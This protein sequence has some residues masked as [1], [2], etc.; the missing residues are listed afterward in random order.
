MNPWLALLLGA[1][2]G[3]VV[4]GAVSALLRRRRRRREALRHEVTTINPQLGLMLGVLRSAGVI[5]GSHDEVAHSNVLA[6]TWGLVRGDRVSLT[7][8]LELVREVRRTDRAITRDVELKR[9]LGTPV[10]HLTVRVAPLEDGA[11]IVL[12]E[13]RSPLLRVDETRRD[14][15]A[16]VSHELKT[17]IGAI[18]LLA[19]ALLEAAD[20]PGAVVHFAERMQFEAGRLSELVKQIIALSRLQSDDPMLAAS[21]VAIGDLSAI[22]IDRCR[23]LAKAKDIRILTFGDGDVEILGDADQLAEAVTNLLQ[24]AIA[25]S[26]AHS[27]VVITHRRVPD[28]DQDLAEIAVADNGIGIKPDEQ[29]RIFERFYRV[30]YGR[31]R[32]Q[33]GTGLGLSIVKHIAAVHA[34]TVNVWSQVGQGSTFTLSF[35]V[36]ADDQR[37]QS[38]SLEGFPDGVR[39]GSLGSTSA[40]A[41]QSDDSPSRKVTR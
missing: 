29:E 14:F 40:G 38:E 11:I 31:S 35:P 25:Y 26:D 30:D 1:L 9:G 3:A 15:V 16:N 24:N 12:A 33:G 27:R 5:V 7:E 20:D 2:L 13:D 10:M 23:A 8:V 21:P 19:E 28:P 41:P 17:P 34:G 32:D 22:A 36:L 39:Q 4:T 18:S 37:D 6:R